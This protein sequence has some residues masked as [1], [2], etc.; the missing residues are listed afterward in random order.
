MPWMFE[1]TVALRFLREGRMQSLLIVAGVA[2]GVAVVIGTW[3]LLVVVGAALVYLPHLPESFND[4]AGL[5]P[6]S[7]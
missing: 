2:A 1:W 4:A 7:R 6:L 3:G 5:E